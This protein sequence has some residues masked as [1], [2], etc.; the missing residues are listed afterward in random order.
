MDAKRISEIIREEISALDFFTRLNQQSGE[1][2]PWDASTKME[3]MKPINAH[4]SKGNIPTRDYGVL[5]GYN[6]WSKNYRGVMT[7][8]QYC[9]KFQIRR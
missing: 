8:P 6:D 7:Y 5:R 2:S 4:R 9:D 1:M 3:R